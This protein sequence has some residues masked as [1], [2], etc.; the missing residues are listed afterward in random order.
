MATAGA[1]S[2]YLGSD[3]DIFTAVQNETNPYGTD[4]GG[5]WGNYM[6]RQLA[7]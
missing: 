5:T 6:S 1:S 7:A 2:Q 4:M 3:Y